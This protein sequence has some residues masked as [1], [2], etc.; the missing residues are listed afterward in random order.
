MCTAYTNS[1]CFKH[2]AQ[3]SMNIQ[4][5]L[6]CDYTHLSST[7]L[8]N[9]NSCAGCSFL[10]L[11]GTKTTPPPGRR[12]QYGQH[13][14]TSAVCKPLLPVQI[15]I[16]NSAVSLDEQHPPCPYIRHV[17]NCTKLRTEVHLQMQNVCNKVR[18]NWPH[19]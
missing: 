10:L 14:S 8:H 2:S 11:L 16:S 9:T 6:L 7:I 13:H 17:A 3:V 12:L 18:G 19:G 15:V 5:S 4:R 1:P